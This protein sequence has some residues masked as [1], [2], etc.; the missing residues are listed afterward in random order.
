VTKILF[1]STKAATVGRVS[2][3]GRKTLYSTVLSA[4]DAGSG[5]PDAWL[6]LRV[7]DPGP[8]QWQSVGLADAFGSIYPLVQ[9]DTITVAV[10][11]NERMLP[12]KVRDEELQRRV[13]DIKSREGRNPSKKEYRE[14]RDEV[15]MALLP[16]AFIKRGVTM[17]T[18]VR[19]GEAIVWTSSARR[20]DVVLGVFRAAVEAL[21][22]KDFSFEGLPK[23]TTPIP[24]AIL[25]P[26]V[27]D[28]VEGFSVGTS[29]VFVREEGDSVD[30]LVRLKNVAQSE[31]L[32]LLKQKY[33][34]KAVEVAMGDDE[35]VFSLSDKF[36]FTK[37]SLGDITAEQGSKDDK[38]LAF[39]SSLFLIASS[40][41]T[42][43][44]SLLAY[45]PA[46][47][48]DDL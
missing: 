32:R 14:L 5:F 20:F 39:E 38:V 36:V 29:G 7:Q 15:E 11:I 1:P 35:F 23:D 47:D 44:G 27:Q 25:G 12:A 8:T 3:A 2:I 31:M 42:A 19:S 17:V 24:G 13:A 46:D 43:V 30:P 16:K 45:L 26:L 33:R 48:S 4:I 34:V 22:I 40:L 18:L 28:A 37:M 21:E 6:D 41:I 9:Q 10:Q